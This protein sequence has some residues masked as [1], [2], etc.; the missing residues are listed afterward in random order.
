MEDRDER[1]EILQQVLT[2]P[3]RSLPQYPQ[4]IIP[5]PRAAIVPGTPEFHKARSQNYHENP[6]VMELHRITPDPNAE[7]IWGYINDKY[8]I[9]EHLGGKKYVVYCSPTEQRQFIFGT[10]EECLGITVF[11]AK[12]DQDTSGLRVLEPG[13]QVYVRDMEF[14]FIVL[15]LLMK[16]KH[17]PPGTGK[18]A[19]SKVL[20]VVLWIPEDCLDPSVRELPDMERP[21]EEWIRVVEIGYIDYSRTFSPQTYQGFVDTEE[22]ETVSALYAEVRSTFKN[23]KLSNHFRF[24]EHLVPKSFQ[25]SSAPASVVRAAEEPDTEAHDTEAE[26]DPKPKRTRKTIDPYSPIHQMIEDKRRSQVLRMSMT[27]GKKRKS[28]VVPKANKKSRVKFAEPSHGQ[29]YRLDSEYETEYDDPGQ[30]EPE[31]APVPKQPRSR[32]AKE[33]R[34]VTRTSDFPT[35]NL[36]TNTVRVPQTQ[37]GQLPLSQN[38]PVPLIDEGLREIIRQNHEELIQKM[39]SNLSSSQDCS[40]NLLRL[41]GEMLVLQ[42]MMKGYGTEMK[43][44]MAKL[45]SVS[46]SQKEIK[47]SINNLAEEFRSLKTVLEAK[48]STFTMEDLRTMEQRRDL[49]EKTLID[50]MKSF[51]SMMLPGPAVPFR[52]PQLDYHTPLSRHQAI[53]YPGYMGPR[54]AQVPQEP[55]PAYGSS[56]MEHFQQQMVQGLRQADQQSGYEDM[57]RR[58]TPEKAKRSTSQSSR[59]QV[60]DLPGPSSEQEPEPGPESPGSEKS[61]GTYDEEIRR[62]MAK[63]EKAKRRR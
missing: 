23:L 36:P 52:E 37:I 1:R 42:N 34:V 35:E 26:Q 55:V 57:T 56:M 62:I 33:P 54:H 9:G 14:R 28:S 27:S 3:P 50:Q 20:E 63:K 38:V 11:T 4:S 30:L 24:P 45:D 32:T 21:N 61:Q 12:Q 17:T 29:D 53:G 18:K 5:P 2:S 15:A 49:Q 59:V 40:G 60:L 51:I 6:G 7:Q 16:R 8:N 22:W 10:F 47:K 31:P 44:V 39:D 25:R 43:N 41:G 48:G 58:R 19:T 13:L 46:S